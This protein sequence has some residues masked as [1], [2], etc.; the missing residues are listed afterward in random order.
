M[1]NKKFKQIIFIIV[2]ILLSL[3]SIA[4]AGIDEMRQ[5]EPGY[6]PIEQD[7]EADHHN[8][9]HGGGPKVPIDDYVPILFLGTII[10]GVYK[11]NKSYDTQNKISSNK[12]N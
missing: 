6:A 12:P 5:R 4:H 2:L 1:S 3:I 7:P 9:G 10:Y 11:I 8:N